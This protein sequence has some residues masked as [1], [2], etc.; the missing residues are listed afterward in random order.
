MQIFRAS[1]LAACLLGVAPAAQ[2]GSAPAAACAFAGQ[3]LRTSNLVLGHFRGGRIV[4]TADRVPLIVWT[5]DYTC[6]TSRRT[7]ERWQRRMLAV[8]RHVEGDT[9]CLPLR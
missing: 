4:R 6:F 1:L 5:D 9:T 7:C 2:A 8:Y 3:E